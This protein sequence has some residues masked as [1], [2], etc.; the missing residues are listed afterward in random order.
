[1]D[2]HNSYYQKVKYIYCK[3]RYPKTNI[4]GLGASFL[5]QWTAFNPWSGGIYG[6]TRASV[7]QV[8]WIP[9]SILIPPTA[10]HLPNNHT[11]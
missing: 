1:M 9:P 2:T 11:M 10:L 3:H 5:M 8:L 6:G 7:L 4:V